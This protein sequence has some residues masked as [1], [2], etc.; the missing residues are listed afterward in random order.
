[1]LHK[2]E[3]TLHARVG[4]PAAEK[5][6]L[7]LLKQKC[8]FRSSHGMKVDMLSC[9][10]KNTRTECT[11]NTRVKEEYLGQRELVVAVCVHSLLG[12]GTGVNR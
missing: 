8:S 6:L 9:E 4:I 7:G 11:F 12:V 2:S 5:C 1:M 10:R 3:H